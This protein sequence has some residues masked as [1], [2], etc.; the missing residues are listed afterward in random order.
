MKVLV[1]PDVHLK[2]AIFD[3]ATELMNEGAADRVVCLMDLPDDF[4]KEHQINLYELTFDRDQVSKGL[5]RDAMVLRQPRLKLC[6]GLPRD[7]V[8]NVCYKHRQQQA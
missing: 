2:P 6:L 8:L 3:R 4:Q 5:P 7:G 1:I